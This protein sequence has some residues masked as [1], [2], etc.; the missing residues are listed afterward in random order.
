MLA[1]APDSPDAAPLV[2]LARASLDLYP[3]FIANVEA[4]SGRS[5]GYRRS[6]T[7]E[8]F[9]TP[10]GEKERDQMVA[11]HRQL[12]L[13]SEAVSL[14]HAR[15]LEPALGDAARAA[16]WMPYEAAVEPRALTEAVL[17][18]SARQGA[19][20]RGGAEVTSVVLDGGRATGVIA[21]GTKI[22]SGCVVVAAGCYSGGIDWLARYA[23]T[24][25][26]RGQ[27]LS[28]RP[29][30]EAPTRVLR[31]KHGYVVPRDDGRIVAGS[32]LENA[33]FEKFVTASGL[34][35]ILG[36]AVELAPALADAEVLETWAGL[37]PDTPDH[38]PVLGPADLPDLLIATGHYRNGILLAPVTAK[39]IREWI[40][41]GRPSIAVEGFS[42]LRFAEAPRGAAL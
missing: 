26:V 35:Q 15:R 37:R 27:M 12:G 16:A 9:L 36:A 31:S 17:S 34:L 19:E 33:G 38:L 1:P 32:T 3:E 42:P 6:G 20:V 41:T 22:P 8:I 24:R 10:E 18:A 4:I 7:L 29:T 30:R 14:E 23:P 25:P 2:P 13:P 40:T 28:L 11:E 39:L 5:T 21:N